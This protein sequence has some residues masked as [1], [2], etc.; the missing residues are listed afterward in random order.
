MLGLVV[1]IYI[2]IQCNQVITYINK[3]TIVV[4]HMQIIIYKNCVNLVY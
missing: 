4:I 1:Y 2:Y 3:L